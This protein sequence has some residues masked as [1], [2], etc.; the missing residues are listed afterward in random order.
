VS[1]ASSLN[2]LLDVD[3]WPETYSEWLSV[4]FSAAKLGAD[5]ARKSM[6][7][8][9]ELEFVGSRPWAE[10]ALKWVNSPYPDATTPYRLLRAAIAEHA[11]L[12]LEVRLLRAAV[13]AL[14]TQRGI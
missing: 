6:S 7:A 3:E 4:L 5:D 8:A 1:L 11:Q 12:S 13:A 2:A 9:A 10:E 14:K